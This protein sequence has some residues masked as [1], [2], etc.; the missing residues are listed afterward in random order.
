MAVHDFL[1]QANPTTPSTCWADI[2]LMEP[3]YVARSWSRREASG[4]GTAN[5]THGF[6]GFGPA[7][8]RLSDRWNCDSADE[9]AGPPRLADSPKC[10]A[11]TCCVPCTRIFPKW[12]GA[13][14]TNRTLADLLFQTAQHQLDLPDSYRQMCRIPSSNLLRPRWD[15]AYTQT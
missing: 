14:C 15:S 1:A 13:R 10:N 8:I 9:L 12:S 4:G 11:S 6:A 7:S 5:G 2:Q 3:G